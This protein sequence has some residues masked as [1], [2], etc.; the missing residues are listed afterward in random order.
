MK[1]VFAS[2]L[3]F[4]L[5]G[6]ALGDVP[7]GIVAIQRQFQA[8][9][10]M[11]VAQKHA[12]GV[13]ELGQKYIAALESALEQATN[14]GR[15]EEAVALRDE[16]KR[17]KDEGASPKKKTDS[18]APVVMKLR[19]IYEQQL[20]RLASDRTKS[21]KP[22]VAKFA[23]ALAAQQDELTKEGKLD[24]A[25]V[26][27]AYRAG[28]LE[29]KLLGDQNVLSRLRE[30]LVLCYAFDGNGVIEDS[31]PKQNHPT[32]GRVPWLVK[33]GVRGGAADFAQS[34]A[35][36]IS[37][38]AIG[39]EGNHP[40][41]VCAWLK[42]NAVGPEREPLVFSW[43]GLVE[44]G[45]NFAW[46]MRLQGAKRKVHLHGHGRDLTFPLEFPI[47]EWIHFAVTYN[48]TELVIYFNGEEKARELVGLKT[49]NSPINIGAYDNMVHFY[50]PWDGLIDEFMVFD[51][52]LSQDD[53]RSIQQLR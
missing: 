42:M 5:A 2:L 14:S 3:I 27:K 30:H 36:L 52:A 10:Q 51:E 26:V 46:L 44:D 18:P 21:A 15:L 22:L 28:N 16:V 20:A 47:G 41:T 34:G 37:K 31:S 39:I 40:R 32:A 9:Y 49:R 50:R 11:E 19:A 1:S 48:S 12:S 17:V 35:T 7:T 25:L 33:N 43:G 45:S 8:T 53:I 13:I 24:D 23:A 29:E 6:S 4:T 38:S